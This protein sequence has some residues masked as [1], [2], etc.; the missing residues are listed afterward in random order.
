MSCKITWCS[1]EGDL[2]DKKDPLSTIC[3]I[4]IDDVAFSYWLDDQLLGAW[5]GTT[6]VLPTQLYVAVNSTASSKSAAGTEI[7][8]FGRTAITFERV[9]QIQRWNTATV[10]T[11]DPGGAKDVAS[12]A[13]WD[14]PNAGGGNY[15]GYA[16]LDEVTSIE[17]VI[18][19]LSNKFV[20]GMGSI[21]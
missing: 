10:Q 8:E 13:I 16:N 20:I 2:P 21:T 6:F 9:S 19:W 17:N 12:F 14:D 1:F 7:T 15:W 4:E 11:S 18:S 5:D 3:E